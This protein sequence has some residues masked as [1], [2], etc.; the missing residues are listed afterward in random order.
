MGDSG[1]SEDSG[2]SGSSSANRTLVPRELLRPVRN[3]LLDPILLLPP[4]SAR[5]RRVAKGVCKGVA[6]VVEICANA[7]ARA[8]RLDGEGR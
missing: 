6:G 5:S 2:D 8:V 7:R 1:D 3:N 4:A